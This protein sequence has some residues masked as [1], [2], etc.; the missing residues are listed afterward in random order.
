MRNWASE[1]L[2]EIE[3][4]GQY[5]MIANEKSHKVKYISFAILFL[6]LTGNIIYAATRINS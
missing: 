3:F 4:N 5:E 6:A 2:N 1:E